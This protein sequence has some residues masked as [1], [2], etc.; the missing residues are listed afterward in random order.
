LTG[1]SNWTRYAP[2]STA[3]DF[4]AIEE[5]ARMATQREMNLFDNR[6]VHRNLRRGLI[7]QA[8]YDRY[9]KELPDVTDKAEAISEP[10]PLEPQ[11]EPR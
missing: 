11:D 1:W 8:E 5:G 6:I 4:L 2:G 3:A 9:L 7:S 10:Q